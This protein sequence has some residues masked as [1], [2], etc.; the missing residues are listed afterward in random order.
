[1][2][3]LQE[4]TTKVYTNAICSSFIYEVDKHTRPWLQGVFPFLTTVSSKT[5]S[6]KERQIV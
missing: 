1:M 2:V 4:G 5:D 6:T 3:V